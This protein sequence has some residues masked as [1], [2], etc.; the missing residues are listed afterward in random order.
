VADWQC[1]RGTSYLYPDSPLTNAQALSYVNQGFEVSVHVNTGC[2][3]YTS[4]VDL[5]SSYARQLASFASK[6]T[7]VPAPATHRTHCIAWSDYDTQPQVELAHGIRL[8]TNY[9]YWPASWVRDR[10]GFMT[11]SALPM[12]F[13]DRLGRPIDVFQVATQMTDE[14]GQTYPSTID[15]LLAGALGSAGHYG[16][17][18]ANMHTDAPTSPGSEAILAAAKARGVPV[19]SALQL[20]EWLDARNG[21]SFASLAWDGGVL[22]FTV[23]AAP[24]ARN[25]QAMVP[26]RAGGARVAG[27]ARGPDEV[28]FGVWS[29]KGVQYAVFHAT[30][31]R[32]RATYR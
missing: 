14:S 26:L 30:P 4:Y 12:R 2:A 21:S 15:A 3:D 13:A 23:R 20:L 18:A 11:G 31:G 24:R 22:G 9:Y 6:Y 29:V 17:F 8:D 5:D 32:Y 7:S 27:I 16:V 28:P 19:I 10:P 25:L 1:I